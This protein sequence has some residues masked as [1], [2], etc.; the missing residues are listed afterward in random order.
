MTQST[1][2]RPPLR[3]GA[4]VGYCR[5]HV[6]FEWA[7]EEVGVLYIL[8]KYRGMSEHGCPR[9][10]SQ[11]VGAADWLRSG[12]SLLSVMVNFCIILANYGVQLFVQTPV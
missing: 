4:G 2:P 5:I 9:K 8:I 12:W 6:R 3:N 10:G 11:G 7:R 1:Q